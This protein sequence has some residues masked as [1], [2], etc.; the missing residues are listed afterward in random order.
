MEA[1]ENILYAISEQENI[2]FNH[3]KRYYSILKEIPCVFNKDDYFA[4]NCLYNIIH[5]K[6]KDKSFEYILSDALFNTYRFSSID[7]LSSEYINDKNLNN[8]YLTLKKKN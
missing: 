4:L 6:N 7:Y 1:N 8:K 5:N 2:S 3:I